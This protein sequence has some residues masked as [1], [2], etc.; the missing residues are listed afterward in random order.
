MIEV[1][2]TLLGIATFLVVYFAL[3][4]WLWWFHT[5]I[6]AYMPDYAQRR[7]RRYMMI[8]A[9]W[10]CATLWLIWRYVLPDWWI[11]ATP[12]ISSGEE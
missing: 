4:G 2:K 6:A 11:E 3:P 5:Q 9:V 12:M 1:A 10:V 7:A 8:G